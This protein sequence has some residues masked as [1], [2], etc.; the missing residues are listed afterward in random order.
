MKAQMVK[1][2]VIVP[3]GSKG[4]FVLKKAPQSS[5]REAFLQEGIECYTL[6]LQGLL[7][8][9]DN[10]VDGKVVPPSNVVRHDEDDP[11]LVVAADKGTAT[12]SDIANGVSHAYG[13]WLG[14]AFAS[15]GSVGYDH[16]KMAITARGAWIS[17]TRHFKEMDKDIAR[18]DFTCIG[19]GDMAGD[20]FGNGMLL[21]KHTKLLAAFNHQHIFIDPNP[22]AATSFE[23]RQRLFNLPRSSWKD[24]DAKLISQ[25][26]GV[27]ER[28]AKHITI[29]EEAR[30]AIGAS[31]TGFTPDELIRAILTAPADLLWN[32]GIG[33]Y[34]KSEDESHEQV[35]DRANNG[36]RVGGKDL[37][38]KVIGEGGNLGFTQKGRI[39]FAK[40]GGRLNTDAIDNSAGVDCSDH[41]VNI[42]IA[43]SRLLGSGKLTPGKRDAVLGSM[44]DEVAELVLKDNTL[45][46]LALS[47]AEHIGA[48]KLDEQTRLIYALEKKG[49]L[50][51]T[52]EFLPN[53]KQL[54][55]LKVAS[56][57][58]TRPELAVLLSY[59]KM[60][61][62]KSLIESNVL[63]D[64]YFEAE[65]LRYFPQVMQKE[66]RE[67]LAAH[68]LKREIIATVLTNSLVNRVGCSFVNEMVEH[69]EASPRDIAV[70]YALV[71]DAFG[72]RGFWRALDDLTGII[73]VSQQ[74]QTFAELQRFVETL[75]AWLLTHENTP[76]HIASVKTRI[77][78]PAKK[79]AA[80]MQP[81]EAVA[82]DLP[83][84]L[85]DFMARLGT[86]E[87]AFDIVQLSSESGL[88]QEAVA[89][90]YKQ[91]VSRL[92]KS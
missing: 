26:G 65:L 52:I 39:E 73:P 28:S 32:G 43:F 15:G 34:V 81:G 80:S 25:G 24:Y 74:A 48:E 45:Q 87:S 57:G 49:L 19:I 29:S 14:D 13:F 2:A 90:I 70:A 5:D 3:V 9:T 36:V 35:G 64:A 78:D 6:Y 18:E 10:L 33:T 30:V 8:I 61:L 69:L 67:A 55:D 23:E 46:T 75:V 77:I 47:V 92:T 89:K 16:K 7:D 83:P 66:Y 86:F 41:E 71:R 27:F 91:L 38:C 63:D 12:F 85:A 58:L 56:R 37:R 44:T 68:P 42:K 1:N 88:G 11:Y 59:S 54:A 4:G 50:S 51:R 62:Y 21:S 17:V 31:K 53:D 60:D 82:S 40:A 84:P 79:L 76:L 72:L 22:D 20:V